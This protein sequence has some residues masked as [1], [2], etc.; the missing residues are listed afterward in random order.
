M[1]APKIILN[2]LGKLKRENPGSRNG[3]RNISWDSAD[4]SQLLEIHKTFFRFAKA[5]HQTY[6]LF[7]C[8]HG[9]KAT[10]VESGKTNFSKLPTLSESFSNEEI[11]KCQEQRGCRLE[12]IAM[13]FLIIT[14][15][16]DLVPHS[17]CQ[18]LMQHILIPGDLFPPN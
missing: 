6:N 18:T 11:I 12:A 17:W 2:L 14:T 9:Q 8:I 16:A 7:F 4:Q 5:L 13:D 15:W 10:P 1:L 3:E